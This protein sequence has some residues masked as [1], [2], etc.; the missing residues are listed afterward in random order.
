MM[1]PPGGQPV[2]SL[3]LLVCLSATLVMVPVRAATAPAGNRQPSVVST[4]ATRPTLRHGSRGLHVVYLQQRL[5]ALRYDVGPV[6]GS[7]GSS[8]LHG[9]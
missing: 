8:T 5:T 4:A 7:F 1:T 9:V 6:D 2:P 3:I